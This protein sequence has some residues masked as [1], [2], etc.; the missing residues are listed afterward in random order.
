MKEI[1]K[2]ESYDHQFLQ[3]LID[4]EIEESIH[5]EF[6]SKGALSKKDSHKKEVSKDI[7]AFANSDGGILVYGIEEVNHKAHRFSYI[8]GNE[9]TKEWLEQIISTTVQR[10]IPNLK[11]FPI[12]N[13][14]KISETIYIVQVPSSIE[15]P[16]ISRDKRFYKRFN[17]ESVQMEEYEI[18]QLYGRR[19][20][21]ELVLDGYN[22]SQ[23]IE[24]PNDEDYKF[25]IEVF[26]GNDGETSE[27]EFKVNLYFEEYNDKINIHW[28]DF[29]SNRDYTASKIK[30]KTIKISNIGHAIYPD[31]TISILNVKFDIPKQF[32]TEIK[33]LLKFKILLFY[34]NGDDKKEFLFKDFHIQDID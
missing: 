2:L 7:S 3:S 31:E 30:D 22:I 1:H 11:I 34:P 28:K 10:K 9:F 18:R 20:K 5:I 32:Y 19:L 33:N 8:D 27:K 14:G 25:M 16:H 21:S 13:K 23:F 4:N 15:S 12:R 24:Q 6:K 26:V 17:F 29:G